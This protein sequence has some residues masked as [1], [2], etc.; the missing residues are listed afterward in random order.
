MVYYHLT[1]PGSCSSPTYLSHPK[2]T[3]VFFIAQLAGREFMYLAGFIDRLPNMAHNLPMT[4]HL[5]WTPKRLRYSNPYHPWDCYVLPKML[6]FYPGSS[7]SPRQRTHSCDLFG[8]WKRELH[9]GIN[10]SHFEETGWWWMYHAS[11]KKKTWSKKS[12]RKHLAATNTKQKST[13]TSMVVLRPSWCV[14]FCVSFCCAIMFQIPW[15]KV[16]LPPKRPNSSQPLAEKGLQQQKLE[17]RPIPKKKHVGQWKP[18][19]FKRKHAKRTL[20]F[21]FGAGL[22]GEPPSASKSSDSALPS[23]TLASRVPNGV[24]VLWR[25]FYGEGWIAAISHFK[26]CI[27]F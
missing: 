10:P 5:Q 17:T 14:G 7:K 22:A 24:R 3:R 21:G 23:P 8:G 11:L 19:H 4:R 16:F 1:K 2:P 27:S 9:L 26:V 20:G 25:C 15:A 6:M 18:P 12:K 13:N